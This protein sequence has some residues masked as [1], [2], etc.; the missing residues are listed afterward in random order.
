MIFEVKDGI[1]QTNRAPIPNVRDA[2]EDT[3]QAFGKL[4]NDDERIQWALYFLERLDK[5]SDSGEDVMETIAGCLVD[6]LEI[7]LW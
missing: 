2:L 1:R 4:A 7:G 6:R 5:F 3:M